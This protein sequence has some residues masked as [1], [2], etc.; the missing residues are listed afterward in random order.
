MMIDWLTINIPYTHSDQINN[1]FV[2]GTTKDGEVEWSTAKRLPLQGSFESSINVK[3]DRNSYCP[4]T[5]TFSRIHVDGNPVKLFQGHNVFGTDNLPALCLATAKLIYQTLGL[6]PSDIDLKKLSNLDIP[7]FRVDINYSFSLSNQ[8]QVMSFIRSMEHQA[9]LRHRGQGIF[10][11]YT[12]YFGKNSRR[13]SLKIYSKHEEITTNKKGHLLHRNLINRDQLISWSE[14]KLR[15]EVTLRSLQLKDDKLDTASAWVQNTPKDIFN[16]YYE[17]LEMSSQQDLSTDALYSLPA[18]LK[19]VYKLWQ[20]G[21]DLRE[22]YSKS[23][24]YRHR[25]DLLEYGIDIA[26]TQR[27]ESSKSAQIIPLVVTLKAVEAESVPEWA[28]GTDSYFQPE[29]LLG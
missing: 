20:S 2:T 16:K 23:T 25:K 10:K 8:L 15:I 19:P 1:G 11:G 6:K 7:I 5:G 3:T 14:N 28:I 21:G 29:A 12:L 24:F 13:W 9:R 17:G 26:V 18:K 22:I 27:P 4:D